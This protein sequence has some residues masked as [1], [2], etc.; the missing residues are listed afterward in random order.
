MDRSEYPLEYPIWKKNFLTKIVKDSGGH[1]SVPKTLTFISIFKVI[2]RSRPFLKM[3]T[4]IL[5]TKKYVQGIKIVVRFSTTYLEC[6]ETLITRFHWK[7]IHI[8]L[9]L[10]LKF[11]SEG[12]DGLYYWHYSILSTY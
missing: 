3:E 4:P 2:W 10:T 9:K 11:A 1:L 6:G 7:K 5:D 8:N 12:Q